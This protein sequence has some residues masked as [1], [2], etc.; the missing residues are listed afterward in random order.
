MIKK[1]NIG[2]LGDKWSNVM[3]FPDNYVP[4]LLNSQCNLHW[5]GKAVREIIL[6]F[7][8]GKSS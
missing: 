8:I 7:Q 1:I 6:Q 2:G 3:G 4:E 5:H